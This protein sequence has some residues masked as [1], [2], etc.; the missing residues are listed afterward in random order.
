MKKSSEERLKEARENFKVVCDIW[1]GRT[2]MVDPP[3]TIW[4]IVSAGV[5]LLAAKADVALQKMREDKIK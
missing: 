5:S 3:I 4:N 2:I 1:L